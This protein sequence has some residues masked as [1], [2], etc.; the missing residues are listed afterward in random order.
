MSLRRRAVC[1]IVDETIHGLISP[2]WHVNALPKTYVI[3]AQG[4]IRYHGVR[5]EEMDRAVDVLL[6]EMSQR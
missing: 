5:G 2:A 6:K 4:V 1:A 3:D